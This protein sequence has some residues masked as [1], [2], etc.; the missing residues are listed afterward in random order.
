MISSLFLM[1]AFLG[2]KGFSFEAKLVEGAALHFAFAFPLLPQPLPTLLRC[3]SQEESSLEHGSHGSSNTCC[4]VSSQLSFVRPMT[5]SL[6]SPRLS[7]M[8]PMTS[9]LTSP[10]L[11][12]LNRSCCFTSN[13][14]V[15]FSDNAL[16]DLHATQQYVQALALADLALPIPIH[17]H[18]AL[19]LNATT[20]GAIRLAVRD[21]FALG[22]PHQHHVFQNIDTVPL[23]WGAVL[24]APQSTF[25]LP[26][27]FPAPQAPIAIFPHPLHHA[28]QATLTVPPQLPPVNARAPPQKSRPKSSSSPPPPPPNDPS[29]HSSFAS[30]KENTSKK[31]PPV[32]ELPLRIASSKRKRAHDLSSRAPS[33]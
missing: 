22:S 26:A 3:A 4:C 24:H 11:P 28:P 8:R 20:F 21:A 31:K 15:T 14:S 19:D 30:M 1:C 29:L 2:L 13:R 33:H 12:L 16:E 10:R 27:Q 18:A 5:S 32:Q 25:A 7:F 23:T 6:T 9:S 17:L